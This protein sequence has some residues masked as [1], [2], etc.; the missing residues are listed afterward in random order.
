MSTPSLIEAADIP[1][2]NLGG[3]WLPAIVL[4]QLYALFVV[5]L[6]WSV[7][8]L[9]D[10][11]TTQFSLFGRPSK[12]MRRSVYLAFIS[13]FALLL[14]LFG[15]GFHIMGKVK[16]GSIHI[17]NQ[18]Y[19]LSP[20]HL[21]ETQDFFLTHWLWFGCLMVSFMVG[22]HYLIVRANR[23]QPARLPWPLLIVLLAYLFGGIICWSTSLT[24][25]FAA[26]PG[27]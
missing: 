7:G 4:V 8:R 15:C 20:A 12:Q 16:P 5:L 22:V 14:P 1:A 13:V 10:R 9:P 26:L 19:W 17:P 6:I 18:A 25:H 23:R 11:V 2:V 24:V 3:T 27:T 21:A